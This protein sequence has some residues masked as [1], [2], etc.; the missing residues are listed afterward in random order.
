MEIIATQHYLVIEGGLTWL[1]QD[2]VILGSE[3]TDD[4]NGWTWKDFE[5]MGAVIE[6]TDRPLYSPMAEETEKLYFEY[7]DYVRSYDGPGNPLDAVFWL[8][9]ARPSFEAHDRAYYAHAMLE[10]ANQ[11][12]LDR[13]KH[14]T[15][16]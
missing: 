5:E 12:L 14:I 10:F 13:S 3:I 15:R 6:P 9:T 1:E 4:P 11:R 16:H 7:R 2:A 8:R